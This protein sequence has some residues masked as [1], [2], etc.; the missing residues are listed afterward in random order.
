MIEYTL[1]DA[2]GTQYDL[3]D[4]SID[5]VARKS[6]SYEDARIRFDNKIVEKSYLPGDLVVGSPRLMTREIELVLNRADSNF[7]TQLNTLIYNL[8]KAVYLVNKTDSKRIKIRL[9]NVNIIYDRGAHKKS[10]NESIILSCL[11]P[12][13]EDTTETSLLSQSLTGASNN[14][15]TINNAGFLKTYGR[16]EFNATVAVTQI[17]AYM[18]NAKEGIQIK[19]VLFG[20][21]IYQDLV[22]DNQEGTLILE[23][24]YD[25]SFAIE[26]GTGF[27]SF[28]KGS[29][30]LRINPTANC[31][32]DIYWRKRYYE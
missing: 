28:P 20:T 15:I 30:T 21:G 17:T 22:L 5:T 32:V 16:L 31:T 18:I 6:I 4:S 8:E 19:D 9:L 24:D 12:F 1:E 10:S 11:D 13:W 26:P 3:N 7:E 29:D 27:F 2:N 25:R 23:D 14:D